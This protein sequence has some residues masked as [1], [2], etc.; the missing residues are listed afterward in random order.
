MYRQPR[1]EGWY[2]IIKEVLSGYLFYTWLYKRESTL[3]ID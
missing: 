2:A 1:G 3:R